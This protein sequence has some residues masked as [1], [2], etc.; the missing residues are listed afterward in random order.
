MPTSC[1]MYAITFRGEIKPGSSPI[2]ARMPS[3]MRF[4]STVSWVADDRSTK[5]LHLTHKFALEWSEVIMED[6]QKASP[7]QGGMKWE[8]LLEMRSANPNL[9]VPEK[10]WEKLIEEMV[11][12]LPV[13]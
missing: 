6:M 12:N 10:L 11:K 5:E 8:D 1:T 9:L 13:H 7:G 2:H 4:T 3:K